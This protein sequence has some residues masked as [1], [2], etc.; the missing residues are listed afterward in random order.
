MAGTLML[1]LYLVSSSSS[2]AS[3]LVRILLH[4]LSGD[5]SAITY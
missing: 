2:D 5:D 1:S 3:L 4:Y